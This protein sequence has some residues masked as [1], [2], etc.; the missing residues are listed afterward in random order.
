MLSIGGRISL[1]GSI[2]GKAKRRWPNFQKGCAAGVK[3]LQN[4][5]VRGDRGAEVYEIKEDVREV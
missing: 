2:V 4:C 3:C 1:T 5:V